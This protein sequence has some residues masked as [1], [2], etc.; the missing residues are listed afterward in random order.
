M[1]CSECA[2]SKA[3]GE[4]R[5]GVAQGRVAV[6]MAGEPAHLHENR[7]ISNKS[8]HTCRSSTRATT[9]T[10]HGRGTCRPA[11]YRPAGPIP[12]CLYKRSPRRC[13]S[14]HH[15]SEYAGHSPEHTFSLPPSEFSCLMKL[16]EL[17]KLSNSS[18]S[19]TKI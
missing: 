5:N 19:P 13:H 7:I 10:N 14:S 8:T 17:I 9:W 6:M 16:L 1:W 3:K 2:R 11:P 18:A 12:A 4:T 15:R